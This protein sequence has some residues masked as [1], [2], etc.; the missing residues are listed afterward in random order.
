MAKRKL[1]TAGFYTNNEHVSGCNCEECG[2]GYL[3]LLSQYEA[4]KLLQALTGYHLKDTGDW[5]Q[6][7]RYKLLSM[8]LKEG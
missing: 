8:G 5:Y 1:E 7:I 3:L 6:Q 2:P 4:Q